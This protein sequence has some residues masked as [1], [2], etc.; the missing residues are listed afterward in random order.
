[1]GINDNKKYEIFDRLVD[2]LP[3]FKSALEDGDTNTEFED[4]FFSE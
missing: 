4:Y 2:L 3:V 1:M